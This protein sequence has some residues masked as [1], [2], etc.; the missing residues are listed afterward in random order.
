[1]SLVRDLRYDPCRVNSKLGVPLE[2]LEEIHCQ[3][4]GRIEGVSGLHFHTNSEASEF[5]GLLATVRHLADRIGPFLE[6]ME[7]VNLGGGYL[8][9]EPDT[10]GEFD[11]SV[12]LL[13][14]R[15]GLEVFVEPGTAMVRQACYLVA[16][17]VDIFVSDNKS[18]AML[19]ATTNHW[20]EVFEYEFAPDV[21]GDTEEGEYEY[22]LAGGTCLAGD[23]FGT[24]AFDEPLD[25]GS[26]IVFS[27]AGAYSLVKANYFNG[28]NLPSIYALTA[29]GELVLEKKFTFED[30]AR[31]CGAVEHENN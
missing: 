3:A 27:N 23:L 20:P 4:P 18:V 12:E 7:W 15:F 28:I 13:R 17:V 2:Y 29:E 9:D 5:S 1:M 21:I 16:S 26:K 14:S 31:Q 19:D 25:V 10:L 30:F 22:L 6:K 8:F 24:Y 11:N